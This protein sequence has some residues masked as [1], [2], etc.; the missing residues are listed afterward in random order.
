MDDRVGGHP[1]ESLV[2][3]VLSG[4]I[5]QGYI[6]G[7]VD[8]GGYQV[9]KMNENTHLTFDGYTIE[10]DRESTNLENI[11]NTHKK[12]E[13]YGIYIDRSRNG[14]LRYRG[15]GYASKIMFEWWQAAKSK[16]QE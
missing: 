6:D 10:A 4:S 7:V 5:L 3:P 2:K 9:Y 13:F 1:L 11:L 14:Q 15:I 12:A 16:N 8:V